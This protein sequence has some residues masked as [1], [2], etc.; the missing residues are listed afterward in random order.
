MTAGEGAAFAQL[1]PFAVRTD[2][3]TIDEFQCACGGVPL[4]GR[5][6]VIF[7]IRWLALPEIRARLAEALR[8]DLVPI[9]ESQSFTYDSRLDRDRD[10][11]LTVALT[12]ASEPE[13]LTLRGTVATPEREVCVRLETVLRLVGLGGSA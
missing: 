11:F 13:R 1:G 9:H 12:R 3:T 4:P 2:S 6:P 10:Y 5:V 8:T 7:P